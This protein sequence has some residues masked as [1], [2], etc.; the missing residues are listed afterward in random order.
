MHI[1]GSQR[2]CASGPK[3]MGRQCEHRLP[4][5]SEHSGAYMQR[6]NFIYITCISNVSNTKTIFS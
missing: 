3:D 5:P 6:Q 4:Y 2:E 1:Q